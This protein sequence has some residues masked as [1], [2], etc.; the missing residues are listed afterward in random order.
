MILARTAYLVENPRVICRSLAMAGNAG[1]SILDAT[2]L[3]DPMVR[4][5]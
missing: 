1:A 5:T 3:N 4:T 2:G